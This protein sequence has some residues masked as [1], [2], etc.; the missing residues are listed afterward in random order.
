[1]RLCASPL[2]CRFLAVVVAVSGPAQRMSVIEATWRAFGRW[3]KYCTNRVGSPSSGKT[4]VASRVTRK[5]ERYWT[6]LYE[7]AVPYRTSAE[8]WLLALLLEHLHND[9][10]I[11]RRRNAG[12]NCW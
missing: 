1:M 6:S 10:R 4:R 9:G 2:S 8:R 12:I 5:F 7:P 3:L 11:R